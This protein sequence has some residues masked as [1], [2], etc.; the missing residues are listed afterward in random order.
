MYYL[1]NFNHFSNCK[2]S[3]SYEYHYELINHKLLELCTSIGIRYLCQSVYV[4]L[5][6]INLLKKIIFHVRFKR[7]FHF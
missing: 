7:D 3:N 5:C 6:Q 2:Y 1:H 4:K